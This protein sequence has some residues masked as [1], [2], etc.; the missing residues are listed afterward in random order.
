MKYYLA[1][2]MNSNLLEMSHRC[3]RAQSLGKVILPDYKLAF[4]THCDVVYTPGASME[5]VLWSITDECERALDLLEGFP[6]YYDK[7]EV[8]IQYQGRTIRPMIYY[9]CSGFD[10]AAPSEHYLTMVA[11]GYSKHNIPIAQIITALEDI[12]RCTL[13]SAN[14]EPAF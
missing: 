7:R 1:Y 5:C 12:T 9:M 2:G 4:K 14:K 11:E 6:D 8:K 13:L 10:Y 3:P